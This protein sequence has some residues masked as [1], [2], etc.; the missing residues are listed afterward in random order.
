MNKSME[1][2]RKKKL[3]DLFE[4]NEEKVEMKM[5]LRQKQN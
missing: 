3:L 4:K 5:I 1:K 2:E